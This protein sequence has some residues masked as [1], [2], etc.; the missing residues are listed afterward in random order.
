MFEI[1]D[2]GPADSIPDSEIAKAVARQEISAFD[3]DEAVGR[4]G[5]AVILARA[6][7]VT[8]LSI[9]QMTGWG[10]QTVYRHI[11]SV[12][13]EASKSEKKVREIRR[14]RARFE[15]LV[16]VGASGERSLTDLA[17]SLA[18]L[19]E[20]VLAAATD[21]VDDGTCQMKQIEDDRVL[22]PSEH[23]HQAL[24]RRFNSRIDRLPAGYIVRVE[25]PPEMDPSQ[26]EGAANRVL[27]S[28]E[29]STVAA[30]DLVPSSRVRGHELL[31]PVRSPTQARAI[32]FATEAWP[33]IVREAGES[34][35]TLQITEVISP[36]ESVEVNSPSL[37]AFA[38]RLHLERVGSPFKLREIRARHSGQLAEKVIASRIL[39][40]A[41]MCLRRALG[42]ETRP[43]LLATGDDAFD[44]LQRVGSLAIPDEIQAISEPLTVALNT[45]SEHLGP[46]RGG[47]TGSFKTSDGRP[48]VPKDVVPTKD[49]LRQ[50]GDS[51]AQAI[52]EASRRNLVDVE[53]VMRRIVDATYR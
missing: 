43:H 20:T 9:E 24:R 48:N 49:S 52:A 31:L 39:T 14:A 21:L 25:I 44:E 53:D 50:I 16:L 35:S 26:I 10:R 34:N 41:A 28:R 22:L 2:Q 33:E 6:V 7:G 29:A 5:D 17:G 40:E 18:L 47:E 32:T 15:L 3:G 30:P 36:G 42:D 13:T 4:P 46:F 45:A 8:V 1:Y 38:T 12:L 27:S 19:N 11:D 23:T 37:D 51:S